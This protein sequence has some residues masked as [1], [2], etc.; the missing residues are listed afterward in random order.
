[1][2][3]RERLHLRPAWRI[4]IG[5]NVKQPDIKA[6]STMYE[7]PTI[8]TIKVLISATLRLPEITVKELALGTSL[9]DQDRW[10]RRAARDQSYQ[11]HVRT[12]HHP[13]HEGLNLCDSP[14]SRIHGKGTCTEASL[15]DQY[16][17]ERKGTSRDQSYQHYVRTTHHPNRKGFICATLRLPE[18]TV[19]EI[20]LGTSLED[21]DRWER[22]AARDQSYQYCIRRAHH[23][24]HK[25]VNLCDSPASR[26]HGKGTCT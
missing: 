17:W 21:Q 20:A 1:M 24:N 13:N 5:R 12:A 15:E 22:K 19:K 3:G 8:R 11:Y 7:L 4:K 25:G 9:E 14:A 2:P 26:N 23:P 18:I 6:I 10:E 16:R